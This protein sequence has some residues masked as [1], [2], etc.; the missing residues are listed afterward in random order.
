MSSDVD[1]YGLLGVSPWAT[2]EEIK[3]AYRALARR[4][5]PDTTKAGHMTQMFR[6]I[7]EAY[8]KL[9][10]P[11]HREAYDIWR[12]DNGLHGN[13]RGEFRLEILLSHK[14]L[15]SVDEP[16]MLYV[17][18][19]VLPGVGVAPGTLPLNLCLVIDHST[20][21]KGTR[22]QKVKEAAREI[23]DRLS[24]RDVFSLVTFSDRAKAVI[25]SQNGIN[26]IR[27]KGAVGSIQANG[28]TEIYHGLVEGIRQISQRLSPKFVNHIIL[29]TDGQTYGDEE[30]CVD[31]AQQAH[32]SGIAISTV[33]IGS[34]WND[35]L[36]DEIADR[37]GG[38]SHY[39]KG[40]GEITALFREKVQQ[41][42]DV[43]AHN[44]CLSVR[45]SED[46]LLRDVYKI[47]PGLRQL[48]SSSDHFDLGPIGANMGQGVLL[49]MLVPPKPVGEHL[50]ARFSVTVSLPSVRGGS[51]WSSER[52]II[53]RF[54]GELPEPKH[55]PDRILS[56]LDNINIYRMQQKV[57]NDIEH[58]RVSEVSQR[59]ETIGTRL[60]GKGEAEL[61]KVALLEAGQLS[62]TG[63]LSPEGR[64]ELKYGTRGLL[65]RG[66][67]AS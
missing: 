39:L 46:V 7:H 34:D 57:L 63:D 32:A 66:T 22:L 29:L 2:E 49:E 5:H 48:S 3:S 1:Y 47:S 9:A 14:W 21:M 28:A 45:M 41:L 44:A 53:M 59:L 40:P 50:L 6:D 8:E 54:V 27:A 10:D 23:V 58:G 20:S 15:L 52:E 18:L 26:K 4:Y 38:S 31:L 42:A 19:D 67:D 17:I 35:K 13:G 30:L 24:E 33:G 51:E 64:K 43:F 11:G 36:L 60:L 62:K 12:M 37:S 55:A 56:V 16:Q 25:P 61:A 65:T